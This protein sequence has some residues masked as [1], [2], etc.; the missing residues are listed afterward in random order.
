MI[1]PLQRLID[2]HALQLATHAVDSRGGKAFTPVC[3]CICLSFG[4][5]SQR[6]FILGSKVKVTSHKNNACR[7]GSLH[8]CGCRRLVVCILSLV[9]QLV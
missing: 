2:G 5:I 4:T 9:E 7:R 6:T 3:L 8:S 1:V